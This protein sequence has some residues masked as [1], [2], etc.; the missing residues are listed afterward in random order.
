MLPLACLIAGLRGDNLGLEL[1][2]S[3]ASRPDA[4]NALGG[5]V[6]VKQDSKGTTHE[7]ANT[8]LV[9][10]YPVYVD[11]RLAMVRIG[12]LEEA[13]KLSWNSSSRNPVLVRIICWT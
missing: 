10:H 12:N 4:D 7:E 13:N 6:P 11:N 3:I 5:D 9:S 1:W 2:R 8:T